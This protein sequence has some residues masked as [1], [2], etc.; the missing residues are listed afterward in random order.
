MRIA[1]LLC[2][3]VLSVV[4]TIAQHE[5]IFP[6]DTLSYEYG[7]TF[8][9]VD[10]RVVITLP[11][12]QVTDSIY[13]HATGSE[14]VDPFVMIMDGAQKR[15]FAEVDDINGTSTAALRFAVPVAGDYAIVV[16]TINDIGAYT[17]RVGLNAPEVL[18]GLDINSEHFN[19]ATAV[20]RGRPTLSGELFTEFDDLWVIHYTLNGIDATTLEYIDAMAAAV[21]QALTVQFDQLGW[22][23]PPTDCGAGG[24]D[25]LDIYVIDLSAY[26]VLGF[27][28]AENIVGDNPNTPIR[29][30]FAAYGYLMIDNDMKSPHIDL[31]FDEQTAIELMQV[32][33]AH[34]LHHLIQF[35]YDLNDPFFGLYEAGATWLETLIYPQNTAAAQQANEVLA[36]PD[37]CIGTYTDANNLRVY[38]E[39][40][41]LDSFTRDLGQDAYRLVWEG[42]INQEG[43]SGFYDGLHRLGTSPQRVIERMAIRNLLRDYALGAAFTETVNIE[44]S[45]NG[46]GAIF[47]ERN[48]VQALA[49]DYVQVNVL[50]TYTFDLSTDA[51]LTLRVVGVDMTTETAR[52]YEVG[53]RGTVDL[54]P[55]TNAFVLI[56]NTTL[57]D[58][59]ADCMY[60]EWVLQVSEVA[61]ETLLSPTDEIWSATHFINPT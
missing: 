8:N 61:T 41:M 49:V 20:R 50:D 47:P 7:G 19:C 57:H 24:D 6:P 23:R 25:R 26:E 13:I 30:I 34:E 16:L 52:V 48:G 18:A 14:F 51:A 35:G 43:L 38:G 33:V 21:Q 10:D 17:I 3:L 45:I 37:R 32:T 39:W 55:Y 44:A 15:I 53:Q 9:H 56:L 46:V 42:V 59:P 31:P 54:T 5:F 60:A 40:L 2:F 11:D 27:A 12:L 58:D 1:L 36:Q 4:S 22:N 28:P 29:E